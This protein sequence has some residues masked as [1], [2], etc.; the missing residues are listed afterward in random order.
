[1]KEEEIEEMKRKIDT[2]NKELETIQS[3]LKIA[4]KGIRRR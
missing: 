2:L 1:M 3:I 4:F